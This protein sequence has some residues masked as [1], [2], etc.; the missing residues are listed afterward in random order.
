MVGSRAFGQSAPL[1]TVSLAWTQG[2]AG[3]SPLAFGVAHG[4]FTKRGVDV[5][6]YNQGDI[7]QTLIQALATDKADIGIGLLLDS[8]RVPAHYNDR[9]QRDHPGL[10]A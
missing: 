3:H 1:K 6:L 2:A 8:R 9:R 5:V 7:G 10:S 4:F